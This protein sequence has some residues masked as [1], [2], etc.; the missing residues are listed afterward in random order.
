MTPP[1]ARQPTLSA[2]FK[3]AAPQSDAREA[4]AHLP[5]APR[6]ASESADGADEP[7]RKRTRRMPDALASLRFAADGG[8][9]SAE[10]AAEAAEGGCAHP[11]PGTSARVPPPAGAPASGRQP[12]PSRHARFQERLF[13]A[14]K[15]AARLSRS[16]DSVEE[17]ATSRATA[18]AS[19]TPPKYTPLEK[20][21]LQLKAQHPGVLLLIEVGYKMKMFGD[22][23]RIASRVLNIASYPEKNL[24][25]AMIPV[26][27]LPVHMKRLLAAGYKVGVCRQ[28]ETRAL[29]AA[30][31]NANKPFAR[32]L[33][34][35][36]TQGTWVDDITSGDQDEGA[37]QVIVAVVERSEEHGDRVQL[38]IAAADVATASITYDEF[39]DSFLRGELETRLAH[40]APREIILPSSASTR[41]AQVLQ[42]WSRASYSGPGVRVETV[43]P[44]AASDA[45][46]YLTTALPDAGSGAREGLLATALD[47]APVARCALA[48]LVR[49]LS[50]YELAAPFARGANCRSFADRTSMLLNGTTL[51]NLELLQNATTGEVRGSLFWHLDHCR[52]PMGRRLL[53]S[54]LLRPLVDPTRIAARLTAVDTVRAQSCD[55]VRRA[56]A[57]LPQLPDLARGVARIAYGLV[58]PPELATV[59]LSLHRVTHEF[60]NDGP[61]PSGSPE[62]DR[63]VAD[64]SC[65]RAP[66]AENLRAIHIAQARKGDKIDLFVDPQR[67][68]AVQAVKDTIA[69]DEVSLQK[70]LQELRT[71]LKRPGLQY[72]N[73]AGIENLIEVRHAD[74]RKTPADWVRINSTKA[75]VRFH[76]PALVRLLKLR[77]QHR[78]MLAREAKEAFLAFLRAVSEAYLAMRT[79]VQALAELD[80]FASLAEL[81][82]M[83]G[84][85]QPDV[86]ARED[87]DA[88]SLEGFR[89]PVIEMLSDRPYVPN[90][91]Q[92]GGDAPRAILLTG[93]NMGG[94]SSTVR[95]VALVAIMAQMGSF[96]PCRRA[97]LPCHDS[98][99]TRMGV[100][101][102][103]VRGKSTFMVEAEETAQILRTA[104]KRTLICA[105]LLHRRSRAVL[106]EFGRGTST[107]DGTALADAVLRAFLERRAA[108]PKLLFITH[109]VSLGRLQDVYPKEIRNM[110]VA[111]LLQ[112]TSAHGDAAAATPRG[113]DVVFLH[114]LAPGLA[115]QSF[116]LEVAALA[117]LPRA[118]IEQARTLASDLEKRTTAAQQRARTVLMGRLVHAAFGDAARPEAC[119]ALAE[120]LGALECLPGTERPASPCTEA[121]TGPS[122]ACAATR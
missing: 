108:S 29:K 13:G 32:A 55:A 79:V 90:D 67:Y 84:Y 22:D 16:R 116:G 71:L 39:S 4:G 95:A 8:G 46:A 44:I 15:G 70:H 98:V 19:P 59:L 26:P 47:L 28:T 37:G 92:L 73:V 88:L 68:P 112:R 53:R 56:V 113:S 65:A 30:A 45:L 3:R 38:G 62:L 60:A 69:A 75:A 99:A 58:E 41:T 106:D 31:E 7:A 109:Y 10:E 40:L 103:L 23:A 18:S 122:F 76:T 87:D 82:R 111:T 117:G 9:G 27:R 14:A 114:T 100:H 89:H 83:P 78:E 1:P 35:L 107:F 50:A 105:Y 54:W 33:T 110:H 85:V 64:L 80:A 120:R 81:A 74:V 121:N 102:D 34:G 104:T 118:L 5:C 48:L 115:S 119:V 12:V 2:F 42:T 52:T 21:I 20:Q 93:S 96:V 51:R 91:V 17:G 72:L 63:L 77:E 25:S 36:Y 94:K 49:Y 101:D 11:P 97:T 66:V 57:L 6:S 61:A 24:I 43:A 86:H